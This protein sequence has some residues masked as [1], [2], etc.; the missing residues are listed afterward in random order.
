MC[1]PEY[2]CRC[3]NP[4]G[5]L[6]PSTLFNGFF[7]LGLSLCSGPGSGLWSFPVGGLGLGRPLLAL[8][9]CSGPLISCPRALFLC[10]IPPVILSVL[11]FVLLPF[12]SG[13]SKTSDQAYIEFESIEAIVKTASRTKFFIEFY[14]T[15]LEGQRRGRGWVWA[16][17]DGRPEGAV[18]PLLR[19]KGS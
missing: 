7:I 19:G 8:P 14:S 6:V 5:I 17:E 9:P 2:A 10:P 18:S 15:C 16:K 13:L 3:G 4:A 11:L 12:S 1:V